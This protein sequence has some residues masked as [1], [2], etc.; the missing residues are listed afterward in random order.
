[1]KQLRALP[2]SYVSNIFEKRDARTRTRDLVRPK[3]VF[4]TAVVTPCASERVT[5][6]KRLVST[7]NS[8]AGDHPFPLGS[9]RRCSPSGIHPHTQLKLATR[10]VRVLVRTPQLDEAGFEARCAM[11]SAPAFAKLKDQLLVEAETTSVRQ[12]IY[13]KRMM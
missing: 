6:L 2:L 7:V 12:D 3:H 11:Y 1:M 5:R 4:S 9:L 8:T 10:S 13:L